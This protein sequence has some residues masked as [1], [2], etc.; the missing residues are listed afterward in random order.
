MPRLPLLLPA[1]G[2][3]AAL[4][5]S[6]MPAAAQSAPAE[7]DAQTVA[8]AYGD[9]SVF[10]LNVAA[11]N[12]GQPQK[13][14]REDAFRQAFA[15]QF[16]GQ[17]AGLGPDDQQALA[18]LPLLDVQVHQVW[19]SLPAEQRRA[20]RDRWA[21]AVQDMVSSAPCDLFDA[22]ARAQLLP[23]FDQYKQTNVNHLLQCW[24]DHPE[25]TQDSQERAS[26]Q[27]YAGG[28]S[29]GGDHATYMA[30]FNA[31]MLSFTAGMNTASMGT[32]TYT[33]K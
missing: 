3:A 29:S 21:A 12:G 31:N 16:A 2:L 22:L 20:F 15:E 25:L 30:M 7:F 10:I 19:P 17:Y 27:G 1:L 14:E 8:A 18:G 13:P 33:W 23:S 28:A 6:A 26:A 24:H 11:G 9:L 4:L 5:G 32:A